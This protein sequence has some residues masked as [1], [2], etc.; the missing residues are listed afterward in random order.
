MNP[1]LGNEARKRKYSPLEAKAQSFDPGAVF[2]KS[3]TTQT[4][5]TL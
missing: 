1:S 2:E 5:K 3:A 4:N